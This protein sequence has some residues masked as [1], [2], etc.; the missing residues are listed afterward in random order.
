MYKPIKINYNGVDFWFQER[1]DGSGPV[2][3]LSHCDENGELDVFS[4]FGSDTFAHV[5]QD[6]IMRRYGEELG[7]IDGFIVK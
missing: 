7:N 1:A 2:S 6:R 4:M 5:G 3:P